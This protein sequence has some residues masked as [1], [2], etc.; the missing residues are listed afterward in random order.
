MRLA[1]LLCCCCVYNM[2]ICASALC[3]CGGDPRLRPLFPKTPPKNNN[4]RSTLK[5]T[6]PKHEG[7]AVCVGVYH[8]VVVYYII[9]IPMCTLLLYYCYYHIYDYAVINA[10][11]KTGNK[12]NKKPH[13]RWMIR[14]CETHI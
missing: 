10:V 11:Q 6:E 3:V 1:L 2:Y 12:L 7:L 5:F 4:N 9:I 13:R 8:S 14:R